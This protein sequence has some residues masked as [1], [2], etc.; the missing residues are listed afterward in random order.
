MLNIYPLDGCEDGDV[1]DGGLDYL[2][3]YPKGNVWHPGIDL[4][5]GSGGDADLGRIVY[6]AAPGI[7][8]FRHV[9]DGQTY[10]EGTH[11]WI[12]HA[13]ASASAWAHYDHLQVAT[14][15]E[16]ERVARGSVIGTCG[17]SGFQT[18]AHLHF[19]VAR[20]KPA[21]WWQWPRG[22]Q[23][24]RV[25]GTYL[26]PHLWLRAQQGVPI[27]DGFSDTALSKIGQALWGDVPFNLETAIARKY[28]DDLKAGK[29]RGAPAEGEEDLGDGVRL[30]RFR[31]G[32]TEVI[33]GYEG[34]VGAGFAE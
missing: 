9:W 18:W 31:K 22:W 27:V 20:S 2:E 30:Q 15:R 13:G 16:G 7:V 17:K 3:W 21:S 6:C 1:L 29:Y 5:A 4:N 19:E 33:C 11:V 32:T 14:V 28:A 10:G 25:E 12:E 26:N 34:G 8:R 24:S 23:L